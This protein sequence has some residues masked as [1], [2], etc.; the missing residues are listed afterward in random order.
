MI[1]QADVSDDVKDNTRR[2][3]LYNEA[4]VALRRDDLD[5]AAAKLDEYREAVAAKQIPFEVRRTHEI[6]GGLALH[7]GDGEAA[8]AELAQANQQDPWVLYLQALA[9]QHEGDEEGMKT[10][11]AKTAGWNQLNLNLAFVKSKAEHMA[12]GP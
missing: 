6:A 7:R 5:D 9:C 11:A 12:E 1:E 10:F 2:N 4:R 8:L 3:H